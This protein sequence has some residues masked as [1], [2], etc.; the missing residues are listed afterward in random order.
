MP[1]KIIHPVDRHIGN[2]IH[3]RRLA[4][5]ISQE[6]LAQAT[7]ITFQQIQKYERAHN[8]VSSSRLS[9]IADALRVTPGYFFERDQEQIATAQPG[10][11]D[12]GVLMLVR[13]FTGLKPLVQNRVLGLLRAMANAEEV[14]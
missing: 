14:P 3:A 7:G 12:R 6:G 1:E 2:R 10:T 5:G 13:Y 11:D 8:R 4:L 9:E